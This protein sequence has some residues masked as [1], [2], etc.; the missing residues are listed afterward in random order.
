[1]TFTLYQIDAFTTTLFGGNPACVVPL[2]DWLSD[3]ILL[4][5]AKENAV[6][7]TAFF[8]DQGEN[9][10]LRWFTPEIEMD[11]CGHATLAAAHGLRTI[12]G[13]PKEEITF[14]TISGDLIVRTE[15]GL[16]KMDFP[17]R[18]PV[19]DQLPATI[20]KSLSHPPREVYKARDYLLVYDS[21]TA[22]RN[23]TIDRHLFDQINLD[24]GGVIVTAVGDACDFVSRFFTPQ[25]SILEDPV[26]GSAHCSLIPFWSERLHKK[27]LYAQQLSERMGHLYCKDL[28]DRVII[29]GHAKTYSIGSFWL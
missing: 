26:T 3:D 8:V 23:L 24:P 6:A 16:Y 7:E 14:K 25:A 4:K 15:N 12:L 21:E 5:I 17:A 13:Y 27:E 9:V 10:H 22:I 20:A 2:T 1:M 19:P 11:L 18:M 29:S 28:G